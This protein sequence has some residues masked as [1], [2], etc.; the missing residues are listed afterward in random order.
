MIETSTKESRGYFLLE[1]TRQLIK[2][3]K[4]S[5]ISLLDLILK[6]KFPEKQKISQIPKEVIQAKIEKRD[7]F[8][9]ERQGSEVLKREL[10]NMPPAR[11][12][13]ISLIKNKKRILKI[14]IHRTPSNLSYM[15]PTTNEKI[16]VGK[17]NILLQDANVKTIEVEGSNQ[18]AVVTGT[19]GRKNTNITLTKQD[20]EEVLNEF[21]TRS[22][23]P[24]SEGITKINLGNFSLTSIKS[25]E[26]LHIILRKVEESSVPKPFYS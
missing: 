16:N 4:N 13:T 8:P 12:N 19:M 25:G 9:E 20:I 26:E 11:T 6:E 21:A 14:P 3:N 24:I 15:K 1:F 5:N 2:N 10:R 18:N 7:Y 22:K 23:I 17:L